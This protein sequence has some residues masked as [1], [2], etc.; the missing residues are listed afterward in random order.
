MEGYIVQNKFV[1]TDIPK[2]SEKKD[3]PEKEPEKTGA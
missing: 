2:P 1:R 3:G